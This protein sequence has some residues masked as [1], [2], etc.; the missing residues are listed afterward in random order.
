[1]CHLRLAVRFDTAAARDL[2][3]CLEPGPDKNVTHLSDNRSPDT[4]LQE[5]QR[6]TESLSGMWL[7]C[8]CIKDHTGC[9][10][11]CPR[12]ISHAWL[13]PVMRFQLHQGFSCLEEGAHCCHVCLS[14]LQWKGHAIHSKLSC[15]TCISCRTRILLQC[16]STHLAL[17]C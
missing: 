13:L 17:C 4:A 10:V 6:C 2:V 5:R 8:L 15:R 11:A 14:G 12:R 7:V 3:P 9:T 1:M 16:A